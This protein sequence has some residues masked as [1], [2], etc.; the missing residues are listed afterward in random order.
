MVICQ[1]SLLPSSS[2]S[3]RACSK[4]GKNRN[5]SDLNLGPHVRF[6]VNNNDAGMGV[7]SENTCEVCS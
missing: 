1:S 6:V 2:S 4:V 5:V 7:M 3:V